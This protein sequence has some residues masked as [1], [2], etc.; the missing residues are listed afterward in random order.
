MSNFAETTFKL[1]KLITVND[2][3]IAF[4]DKALSVI[5]FNNRTAISTENGVPIEIANS[6]KVNGYSVISS[7]IGCQNKQSIC[8]ASSGVYFIDDRNKTLFNFNK[9]GLT[10]DKIDETINYVKDNKY[11]NGYYYGNLGLLLSGNE[12]KGFDLMIKND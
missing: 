12:E 4:Q 3:I 9:E 1:N 11:A 2:A 8:I 10:K 6:G 5:N 7:N